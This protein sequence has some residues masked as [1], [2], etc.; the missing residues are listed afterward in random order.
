[1]GPPVRIT[2][3]DQSPVPQGST[4]AD[5]LRNTIDLARHADR[6]G[7]H[8]YWLAEHHAMAS[9]ASSAP[10]IMISRVAAE[11][12]GIRVGAGGVLLP[13]YG[14]LKVAETFR[15]LDALDSGRIDLGVGR[16]LAA[17]RWRPV[18]SA[19]TPATR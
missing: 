18:P 1:M 14:P 4:P 5:A 8:R 12:S 6:L 10:E 15:F 11:T 7:Y 16:A 17:T 2:V 3:L 13:Y 19:R 9:H